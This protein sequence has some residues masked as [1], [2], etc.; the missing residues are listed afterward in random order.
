MSQLQEKQEGRQ[1]RRGSHT[2]SLLM[3]AASACRLSC[4]VD[5]QRPRPP[6]HLPFPSGLEVQ[7][8]FSALEDGEAEKYPNFHHS[9]HQLLERCPAGE[10][11]H[12]QPLMP[13]A[14]GCWLQGTQAKRE[15]SLGS[16]SRE[17]G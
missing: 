12:A 14:Q 16:L 6:M 2:G 17:D 11:P 13:A 8:C 15:T 7:L 4:S 1:E 3:P 9:L 10:V 5:Q